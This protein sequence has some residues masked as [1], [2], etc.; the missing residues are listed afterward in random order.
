MGAN[1]TVNAPPAPLHA[2]PFD[3]RL[4]APAPSRSGFLRGSGRDHLA[5][6][7]A[8]DALGQE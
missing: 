3:K 2:L 8:L 5:S 7:L 4:Q 6:G 1:R